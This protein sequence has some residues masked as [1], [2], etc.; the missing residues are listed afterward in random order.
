VQGTLGSIQIGAFA[1]GSAVGGPLVV[2][3][4]PRTCIVIVGTAVVAAG[5]IAA[6]L[7]SRVRD[8]AAR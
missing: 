4:G 2:A 1:L 7:R 5:A 3:L 6:A 8:P